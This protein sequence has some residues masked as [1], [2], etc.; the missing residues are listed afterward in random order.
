MYI[1]ITTTQ[2]PKVRNL[3][4]PMVSYSV[5]AERVNK[6]FHGFVSE[7]PVDA[8]VFCFVAWSFSNMSPRF[9]KSSGAIRFL[10]RKSALARFYSTSL[11]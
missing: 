2:R 3:Y 7:F 5:F 11:A 6:A 8:P 10:S 1:H 9:L 4:H